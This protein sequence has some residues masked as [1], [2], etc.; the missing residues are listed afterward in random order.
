MEAASAAAQVLKALI[1]AR[2]VREARVLGCKRRHCWPL[3]APLLYRRTGTA[4]QLLER[5]ANM[6][7]QMQPLCDERRLRLIARA[8]S[9]RR[10]AHVREARAQVRARGDLARR[11]AVRCGAHRAHCRQ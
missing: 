10:G 9:A 6:A 3:A 5:R 7:L 11:G 1:S 2:N 8:A 4:V